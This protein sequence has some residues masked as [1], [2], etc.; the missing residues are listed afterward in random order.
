M[1]IPYDGHAPDLDPDCF[2]APTA[3]LVGNVKAGPGCSIWFNAVLRGDN[4]S[5]TI[6]QRSNIQDGCI[7]H[8]DRGHPLEIGDDCVVGHAAVLHGCTLRDRVLVGIGARILN[9]VLVEEDVVIAAGTLVP[10][11]VRLE[12]GYLYLGIPA[13]QIRPLR[14]E[15]R[16]R[17]KK[18]AQVYVERG[19]NY[20]IILQG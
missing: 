8:V 13:R 4:D 18:G 17:I 3:V 14:P 9:S 16:E 12:S 1:Q 5:I 15:E 10:E 11:G 7:L 20:R 6:G 2:V 19:R